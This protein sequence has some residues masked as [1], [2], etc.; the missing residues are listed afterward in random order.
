[1]F[2]NAGMNQFKDVFTGCEPRRVP[3]ATTAQKCIRAGGKHNDLDN[4]GYTTRHLTFFEMLGNF[5]FGDYFKREAIGYAWELVTRRFGVPPDRLWITV[6][7][8]DGE[9]RDLWR[10]VAGVAEERIVG[11]GEKDNF[12]SMGDVGPC[13]PCSEILV[14]RGEAYGPADLENGERFFEIWNLVFMQYDQ[15]ADGSRS[16]LPRPS[17][18]TGMGLERMAMVLQGADSVFETDLFRKIIARVEEI[19]GTRYDPGPAGVPHRVLADHVRSLVFA[20]ADGAEPSNEG[21]GYVL[22]RILRRAARYGRKIYTGGPI[23]CR[24]VDDVVREMGDVYPEIG[25]RRE[26]VTKLIESEEDRFGETLD[27]GIE[28]FDG[29]VARLRKEGSTTVPGAEVFKLYDTYGFPA[30]LVER[31]A[32][33]CGLTVDSAGFERLMAEQKERSRGASRFGAVQGGGELE[34]ARLP[35]TRFVGYERTEAEAEVQAAAEQGGLWRLVVEETPFYGESGGQVGDT[36]RIAGGDFVLRVEDTQK[37]R[38]RHIHVCKLERGDPQ[39]VR[40]GAGVRLEVDA[41]RRA[42]IE[43]NHTATHLLHAALRQVVGTHVHQKGSLVVDSRLRFDV[44]HVAALKPEEVRRVEEIVRDRVLA[45][46]AV[47]TFET[48]HEDAVKRGAMA[49]FGEKYGDRVRVVKIGDFSLELCGGTHVGRTGEIGSFVVSS[50]SSVS[51]GVRRLEALTGLGAE[52]WHG[53]DHAIVG[54]L[55][56]RLKVSP[57]VLLARIEKLLEENREL[58]ARKPAAPAASGPS[59]AL[60]RERVGSV[61]FVGGTVPGGDGKSLR[62]AY[63]RLKQEDPEVVAALFAPSDGKVQ[64]LVALSPSLAKRGLDAREIFQAGADRLKARGGGRPEMVQAGG[65]GDP[66]AIEGALED[67]LAALKERVA[68]CS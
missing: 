27:N 46:T 57:E 11:L 29:V 40:P 47:E 37:D 63:D 22:R 17:I 12:W 14:D 31:M 26:Y 61:L 1:L 55:S 68:G 39:K 20:F 8:D 38:G 50:E 60:R 53:R 18:D 9:A 34:V 19:T 23:L 2:T 45:D 28:L 64:V 16:P 4:V 33:E 10:K 30:D 66:G 62:E 3:R 48:D 65:S 15:K 49:L 13:G 67:M 32:A 51:A 36:G 21:R 41:P 52:E 25:G 35:E 42:A 7:R 43:R 54:E 59:G 44:T 5:S 56:R 58:K 24:L 6:Y